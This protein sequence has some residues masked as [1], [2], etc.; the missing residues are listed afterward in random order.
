MKKFV[1]IE[2]PAS[3]DAPKKGSKHYLALMDG[4][5]Q[6]LDD[7]N[8]STD[9]EAREKYRLMMIGYE[10][11]LIRIGLDVDHLEI[12]ENTEVYQ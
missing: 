10:F 4:Y 6:L 11:A 8:E 2:R 3:P 9:H 5:K 7:A 1:M 12:D